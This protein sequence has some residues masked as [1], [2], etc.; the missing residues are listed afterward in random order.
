MNTKFEAVDSKIETMY[1]GLGVIITLMLFMLGYMIWHRRTA[2]HP[3]QQK[4]QDHEE[5]LR[6]LE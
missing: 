3:V 5:R 6:K 2:M 4:S 1:W